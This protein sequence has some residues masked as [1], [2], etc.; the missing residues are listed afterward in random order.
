MKF[1]KIITLLA[2]NLGLLAPAMA[3]RGDM[4]VSAFGNITDTTINVNGG[5]G[6]ML[7]DSLKANVNLSLMY[8][9]FGNSEMTS[10]TVFLEAQYYFGN[11][12]QAESFLFSVGVGILGMATDST[13]SDSSFD[14]SF[15]DF[16]SSFSDFDSSFS[17]F[18]SS[19]SDFDSSSSSSDSSDFNTGY[20]AFVQA[21]QFFESYEN[22]SVF[23]RL[24]AQS[25]DGADSTTTFTFGVEIYF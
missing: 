12:Y 13:T 25:V 24:Q 14:S 2:L 22:A 10:N 9:D 3:D 8:S 20:H 23:Y 16:D 11:F 7:T 6:F 15:S 1:Y 5:V 17:D 21:N 19:F 18:D 4:A